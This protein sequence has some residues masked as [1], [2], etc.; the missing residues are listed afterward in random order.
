MKKI[1]G[2]SALLALCATM[3]RPQ[4]HVLQAF[5]V[6]AG[7]GSLSSTSFNLNTF[8]GEPVIGKDSSSSYKTSLGYWYQVEGVLHYLTGNYSVL[9]GWNMVSVPRTVSDYD[10]NILYPSATSKAF[11]YAGLYQGGLTLE[12]KTGYWLKFAA[13][14]TISYSGIP[15]TR[16]TI[17]VAE[18][19]NLIGSIEAGIPATSVEQTP[20]NIVSS[21][22][23]GYDGSGYH[24]VSMLEAGKAYWV[25]VR[26]AGQLVL[27]ASAVVL[28]PAVTPSRYATAT[29]AS[30]IKEPLGT[31]IVQDARKRERALYFTSAE[32][33]LDMSKFELPP[34]P[35]AEILDVRYVS[36]R[37]METVESGKAKEIL[38]R[39]SAAEYPLNISW[40]SRDDAWLFVNNDATLLKGE[41]IVEIKD[42][43]AV[44]KLR[45]VAS[46]GTELPK[47]FA[48]EQNFPNPFNPITV[49]RYQIPAV[50]AIHVGDPA[51]GGELPVQL[52]VYNVLG[53][54]VAVLVDGIQEGGYKSVE[55]DASGFPSGVY[56]YRIQAGTFSDTK[57]LIL[58][59]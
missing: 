24:T 46:K 40:K 58:I 50:G 36:N 22:Y 34:L 12:N 41:G 17:P 33:D 15:R 53:Q 57:K 56:F 38:L 16:D 32:T 54:E 39:I 6:S 9:D 45:L 18:K 21:S 37:S 30:N 20:P 31:I 13:G 28:I 43:D 47:H 55:W 23:F 51:R 44:I 11:R 59:K 10:K 8:L 4:N 27:T 5:G 35:P 29:T 1:I 25:K 3:A 2:Y 14:Q 42:P 7:G 19:W 52:R 26:Q 48:L 49:I